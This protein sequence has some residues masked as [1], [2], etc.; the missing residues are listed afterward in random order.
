M[1]TH[2]VGEVVGLGVDPVGVGLRVG[3]LKFKLECS[4]MRGYCVATYCHIVKEKE[5][6]NI[7]T[8]EEGLV[9]GVEVAQSS[10][11]P[12]SST[13]PTFIA[14]AASNRV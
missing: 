3:A 4:D 1:N 11:F 7:C 13:S 14:A 12:T 9:V 2:V 8:H 10:T 6:T 5:H